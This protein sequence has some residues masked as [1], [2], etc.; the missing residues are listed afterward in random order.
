MRFSTPAALIALRRIHSPRVIASHSA[1][2]GW[3]QGASTG[4]SAAIWSIRV[5]SSAAS[6]RIVGSGGTVPWYSRRPVV[7]EM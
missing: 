2:W 3:V 1:A 7:E 6:G 5:R 4:I